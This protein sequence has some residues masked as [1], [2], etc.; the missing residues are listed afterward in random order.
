MAELDEHAARKRRAT[1]LQPGRILCGRG[2]PGVIGTIQVCW[3]QSTPSRLRQGAENTERITMAK[4]AEDTDVS[5]ELTA[6]FLAIG[7]RVRNLRQAKG[8]TQKQLAERTDIHF[9]YIAQVERVGVN[10][11]MKTLF[12][13]AEALEATIYDLLPE[14]PRNIDYENRYRELRDRLC[15]MVEQ[16]KQ[17]AVTDRQTDARE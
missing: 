3:P 2:L 17:Q 9:S 6:F 5:P 15:D 12:R 4:L 7:A 13:L 14:S 1:Q 16:L 11:S 8:L 10:L